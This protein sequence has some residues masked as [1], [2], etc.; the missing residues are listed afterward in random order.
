MGHSNMQD[1]FDCPPKKELRIIEGS[2]T[3]EFMWR[4]FP[5][6]ISDFYHFSL[7]GKKSLSLEQLKRCFPD[8]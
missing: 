6:G 7:S 5:A 2:F 8:D 3:E 4:E 1:I